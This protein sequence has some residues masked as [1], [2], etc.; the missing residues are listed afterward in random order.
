MVFETIVRIWKIE[1]LKESLII[2]NN[3][4]EIKGKPDR[5]ISYQFDKIFDSKI[6]QEEIYQ[7]LL[8]KKLIENTEKSINMNIIAYGETGSGKTHTLL[9][10]G[11]LKR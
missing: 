8:Q 1:N 11:I 5:S 4:I 3:S 10:T 6:E 7:K 9:G 2:K